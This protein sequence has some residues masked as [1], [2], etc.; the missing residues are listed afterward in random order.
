MSLILNGTDSSATT[1]AVTGG[2]GG[3]GTGVYYPANNQVALSTNGTQ[4]VLVDASGNVGIGTTSPT[5]KT[6]INYSTNGAYNTGLAVNNT[7][8]GSS[9]VAAFQLAND[10][11]N[12]AGAYLTSSTCTYY[13]GTNTFNLGTVESIPFTFLTGN[14]ERM[15][16]DTSG[17]L[18]VGATAI[19]AGITTAEVKL[20]VGGTTSPIIKW[21]STTG[22]HAWDI[23][24]NN[25]AQLYYAYDNADKVSI[26]QSTGAYT[27]LSDATKKKDFEQSTL[28][29][30][31]VMALK[32]T[33]FRM[34]DDEESTEKQLGFLAQDVQSVIPQAYTESESANGTFI[35]LQDRPIIAVLTKAIQELN[36][37]VDAQAAEI[38]AFKAQ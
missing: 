6:T 35:G 21:Q 38:K 16:I 26:N 18:L 36:A 25:G 4:A 28:G 34:I 19:T 17:R 13:G 5:G 3:T 11:G 27:A 7:N 24:C 8:S 31:A 10:A 12:R 1:P 33:L 29:L 30:D 20:I 32:P 9:A 14:S 15:R 2:T 22:P 37:K 23:Y